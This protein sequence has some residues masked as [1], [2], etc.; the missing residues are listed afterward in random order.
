MSRNI[1][2]RADELLYETESADR[3]TLKLDNA[4]SGEKQLIM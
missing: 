1:R 3:N 4:K 2:Q